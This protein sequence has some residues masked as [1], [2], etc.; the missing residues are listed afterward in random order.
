M[1]VKSLIATSVLAA[2]AVTSSVALAESPFTANIGVTSN[3]M[4]R[5]VT[6]TNYQSAIQGGLDY[7]FSNGAYVGTW[8][9][10]VSWTDP[11]GYEVDLY[12]GYGF[13][14]GATS[15][16]VG[17]I[18]YG[19]PNTSD[20]IAGAA[21]FGEVYVN[22]SWTWLGLGAAYQTNAKTSDPAVEDSGNLYY[23]ASGSWD[24]GGVGLG[25]TIGRYTFKNASDSDYTYGEVSL[26][27]DDFTFSISKTNADEVVWGD[28]N[29][30]SPQVWVSW[31]KSFDL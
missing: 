30:D 9:S 26:S 1:K 17:Y 21:D 27:K 8:A 29:V 20:D 24:V 18:Y 7:A 28:E 11:I 15:W 25:A 3:Y 16:D 4:W 14:V 10:N 6:Q 19:Y 12:G 22:F 31:G 2:S 23:Y 13:D 5:G